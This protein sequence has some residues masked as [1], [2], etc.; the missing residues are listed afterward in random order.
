MREKP[1]ESMLEI[2]NMWVQTWVFGIHSTEFT[3]WE[4]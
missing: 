2:G 4:E 1:Q 3:S